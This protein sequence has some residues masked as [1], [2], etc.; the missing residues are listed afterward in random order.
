MH[1]L[2]IRQTKR[3]EGTV[4]VQGSKNAVLPM[5][6]GSILCDGPVIFTHCPDISDVR[7]MIS[8]LE[9]MGAEIDFKD[10][11]LEIHPPVKE[12]YPDCVTGLTASA[13]VHRLRASVLFLGSALG[14]WNHVRLGYPG[15]CAIGKRPIDQH[16]QKLAEL[17]FQMEDDGQCV[18]ASGSLK[19][20]SVIKLEYPSVGVTENLILASVVSNRTTIIQN[21]AREPEIH[22]LCNFLLKAGAKILTEQSR[23]DSIIVIEGE[24][25]LHGCECEV[26]GDRIAAGTYAI[27]AAAVGGDVILKQ[28]VPETNRALWHILSEMGVEVNTSGD[29]VRIVSQGAKKLRNISHVSTAPY[30]GFP[31]DLQSLLLPLSTAASGTMTVT[32][33]IFERRFQVLEELNRMGA[34]LELWRENTIE[35]RGNTDLQGCP[36]RGTELR[37]SAAL[38]IAGLM[39]EGTTTLYGIEYLERGYE[40]L[41]VQLNRLGANIERI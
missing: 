27:A 10:G 21:A 6:A 7:S 13:K 14:R 12:D 17:G 30:P 8:I 41:H 1:Y 22:Q 20:D 29:S 11:R 24:K 23:E 40:S 37:G 19:G 33:T 31:T 2:K 32:E 15:G 16:L 5:M 35:V 9:D 4:R 39:A 38:V 25:A 28:S 34:G 3:L 18:C 26:P 36:V